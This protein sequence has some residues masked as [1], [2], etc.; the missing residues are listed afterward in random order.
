MLNLSAH[1]VLNPFHNIPLAMTTLNS[2]LQLALLKR[3]KS[4]N[5]IEKGFTLVELM[6]VI[7][8]VGVLSSVALPNFLSQT[9][10]AKGTECTSKLGSILSQASSEALISTADGDALAAELVLEETT[11]S[12]VCTFTV[13]P[14][15]TGTN[16][17]TTYEGTAVGKGDLA[18][19]YDAKGCA[20]F[21][22]A[23][24]DIKTDT[25]D[26]TPAAS[27]SDAICT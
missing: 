19:K 3:K 14:I 20:N 27:A 10:K 24:R 5:L 17:G 1:D 6:I 22:N 23:K 18:S 2:R 9:V 16:A 12:D 7:V 4:R 21:A 13:T 15:G 26:G 8:I 11:N 25:S